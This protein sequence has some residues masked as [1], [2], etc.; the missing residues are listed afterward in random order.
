[1]GVLALLVLLVLG[2]H[3]A[4]RLVFYNLNEMEKDAYAVPPGAQYEKV[5]DRMLQHIGELDTEPYD[6]HTI[7]AHDGTKL[8]GRYYHFRDGAPLQIQFHGYRGHYARD[9]CGGYQIAKKYGINALVID[10]RAHGRSGGHTIS[11][12]ILERYDCR[13]WVNYACATFGDDTTMFLSGVSM[14]A[15]TVLM[16][17]DLD[18]PPNVKAITADCPYSSPAG[19]IRKV[20][21]SMKLPAALI[22]LF[23][24]LGALLFGHIKLWESSALESVR[25]TTIPVALIHG[26]DDR[27]VP[28]EMSKQIYDACASP[29]VLLTVPN[30]GHGLCYFEDSDQYESVIVAFLKEHGVIK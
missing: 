10:E 20:C 23:V 26:E 6:L 13:D 18:L 28:C 1:M 2:A 24:A 11:F 27:L 21:R 15:A 17:S 5:A 12:G 8:V 7:V 14:G 3:F 9:F 29:K 19:I 30:A 4:Y 22:Y 16:A 25:H